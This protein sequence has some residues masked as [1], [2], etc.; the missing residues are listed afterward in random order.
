[1]VDGAM[2]EALAGWRRYKRG[3]RSSGGCAQSLDLLELADLEALPGSR[4]SR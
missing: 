4:P 3:V 2:F 1:M